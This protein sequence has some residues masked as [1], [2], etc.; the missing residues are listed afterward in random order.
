MKRRAKKATPAAHP[1]FF[2]KR[3]IQLAISNGFPSQATVPE[4][5]L[6]HPNANSPQPGA[7][8]SRAIR[9]R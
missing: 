4:N 7:H 3:K 2:L 8:A 5:K 1:G 9:S 6:I